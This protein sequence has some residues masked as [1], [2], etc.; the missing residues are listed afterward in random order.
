MQLVQDVER[1][2]KKYNELPNVDWLNHNGLSGL[3][4][5]MRYHPEAF[6]HIKQ[7]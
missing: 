1:L 7:K 5:A 2:E 4:H 6:A 3:M